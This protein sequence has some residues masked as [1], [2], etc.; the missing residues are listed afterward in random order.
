MKISRVF[1]I[2]AALLPA[3]VFAAEGGKVN[4]SVRVEE[5]AVIGKSEPRTY[6]GTVAAADTVDIVARVSG[7]MWKAAFKEGGM[8][9]KG[10]LL[11]EIEDTIYAANVRSAKSLLNQTQAEY[12]Y[13][14]QEFDRYQKLL[15]TNATSKTAYDSAVRSLKLYEAKLEEAKA[16]LIL[17]ENDL[18]YTKIH[19]PLSGRIGANKRSEGNYITPGS[20]TLATIVNFDPIKVKFSMSEADY[21][22]HFSADGK[23]SSELS[24]VRADGKPH[25]GKLKLDFVDNQVDSRTGTL[26]LQFECPNPDMEL[27]PGGYVTVKFARKFE[28]PLSAVNISALM[29]DGREHFV[30]VVGQ[31]NKVERRVIKLGDQVHDLQAVTAG[32]APGERVVVSGL[33][34]IAPGAVVN[35][36]AR[37]EAGTG[38]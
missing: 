28:K 2:A 37:V 11:F 16:S 35:P 22:S 8:V 18:G 10:D 31:D 33:H 32:L 27:I 29:T 21:F 6:V 4:P 24:I 23:N 38:K 15:S 30:Y 12:E 1:F 20:G 34:K 3:A 36:V 17:A 14:K 25:K 13:A 7:T 19:A 26:M 5:V 9:K